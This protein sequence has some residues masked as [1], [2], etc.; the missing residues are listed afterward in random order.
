MVSVDE[1]APGRAV[2]EEG[3]TPA[4]A[5]RRETALDA[6]GNGECRLRRG[7]VGDEAELELRVL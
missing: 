1:P 5:R 2:L 3:T 6:P 4:K 7:T